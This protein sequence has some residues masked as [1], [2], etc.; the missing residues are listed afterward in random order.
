MHFRKGSLK[1]LSYGNYTKNTERHFVSIDLWVLPS[2]QKDQSI[3][4]VFL[5]N[6]I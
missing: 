5:D 4:D 2:M 1:Y 3:H 6:F